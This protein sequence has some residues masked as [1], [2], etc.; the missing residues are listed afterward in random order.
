MDG[1]QVGC[2]V[3]RI[4]GVASCRKPIEHGRCIEAVYL[5]STLFTTITIDNILTQ[6]S[7][8]NL[9]SRQAMEE[10]VSS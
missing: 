6:T 7:V 5:T 8:T 9:S 10:A 3:G 1:I 4:I 2:F